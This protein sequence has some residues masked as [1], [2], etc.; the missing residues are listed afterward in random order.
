MTTTLKLISATAAV[1]ILFGGP[2][3][4]KE[5]KEDR[6]GRRGA[7]LFERLDADDSGTIS[8]D[9][10]VGGSDRRFSRFDADGDGEVTEAE[11]DAFIAERVERLK[12]RILSRL[13]ADG[14]GSVS[15]AEFDETR[16]ARFARADANS[17]GEIDQGEARQAFKRMHGRP[18]RDRDDTR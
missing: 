15:R 3:V 6:N 5:G 11:V 10:F 9:E 1:L 17:D 2:V 7:Y 8:L 4:A 14:N 12:R 18:G 13:D 16:K